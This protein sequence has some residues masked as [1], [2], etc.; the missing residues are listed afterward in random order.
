[1]LMRPHVMLACG[2]WPCGAT[3]LTDSVFTAP[4]GMVVAL[5]SKLVGAGGFKSLSCYVFPGG[6]LEADP[7]I[8]PTW[9]VTIGN[10][11]YALAPSVANCTPLYGGVLAAALSGTTVLPAG[12]AA[13][14]GAPYWQLDIIPTHWTG[15]AGDFDQA[16]L[17]A[18]FTVDITCTFPVG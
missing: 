13:P 4:P 2:Q 5:V 3:T 7:L 6:V 15:A 9:S 14:I 8:R 18:S 1:M 12:I 16:G 10:T 17:G 11:V